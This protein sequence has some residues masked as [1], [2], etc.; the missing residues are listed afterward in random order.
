VNTDETLQQF[1]L[2]PEALALFLSPAVPQGGHSSWV[3]ELL[4]CGEVLLWYKA[5]LSVPHIGTLAMEPLQAIFA[6][7]LSLCP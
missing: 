4:P 2:G 7:W 3:R 6:F 1:S 5:T